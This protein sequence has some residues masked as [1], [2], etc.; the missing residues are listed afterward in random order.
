MIYHPQE[1]EALRAEI[2]ALAARMIAEDGADYASAKQ[3]AARQILGKQKVRGDYLPDNAEIEQQVREYNEIFFGDT[4]PAR[5][6]QLRELALELMEQLQEFQPY[7]VGS[8]LNG[9]AGEHSD[10]YLHLYPDNIKEVSIFL[11]NKDVQ[12]DVGEGSRDDVEETLS[13]MHRREGVHLIVHD[14]DAI[15]RGGTKASERADIGALRRLL[16]ETASASD[17]ES[18]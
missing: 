18:E 10:I 1:A 17:T 11:L 3:K 7:L 4:Q 2:A 8:V 14:R 15:R 9:T 5:L 16:E 6:R 13:F 12:F